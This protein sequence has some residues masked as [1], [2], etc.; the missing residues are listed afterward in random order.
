MS[1]PVRALS[2]SVDDARV[3]A[4]A[5]SGPPPSG[6]PG[7]APLPSQRGAAPADGGSFT[8][9]PSKLW[10]L[11]LIF[12][13]ALT[14]VFYALP[15]YHL[16][17]WTPLGLSSVVATV[18]GVHRYQP[19]QRGGW[20]LLAAGQFCLIAGD[21]TYNV[22]TQFFH[23][24]DPYPSLADVFY[25]A[26]YPLSAVGIYRFV[27]SRSPGRD[28]AGLIDALII[29]TG[30]GLLSWLY[31]VTPNIDVGGSVLDR[32]VSVAYPLG[33]V[34]VLSMLLRLIGSGGVRIRAMQLLIVGA[35]GL[36][37]A[38]VLYGVI[39]LHGVWNV[40]G[41]VDSGWV[42]FYL[43]W[44]AAALHPSMTQITRPVPRRLR[45]MGTLR[46]SLLAGVSLIAPAALMAESI[47]GTGVQAK[48]VAIFSAVLFL[49]VIA[50]LRGIL[51]V[52]Q[53][54]VERER[55][56]RFFG[57]A[58]VAAQGL[59]DIYHAALDGA[60]ALVGSKAMVGAEV[61]VARRDDVSRV[62]TTGEPPERANLDE[63]WLAAADGGRL[64]ASGTLSVTPLRQ[65]AHEPAMLVVDTA[66]ALTLDQQGALSTLAAQVALAV[67]SANLGEDLR[68]RRS[69]ERF[70]GLL[71]NTSD[72]IVIVDSLGRISYSTPSLARNLGRTPQDLLG[73]ELAEFLH[74][75]DAVIAR[76]M[77][78]G[79]AA[80]TT[81]APPMTD[82]RLHH[83]DGRWL[84]FEVLFNNLLDDARVGGVVLTMR[85]VSERRQLE[86][87]LKHQAFHDA[88]TGLPNRALFQD[89]AE[90][91][92]A[93]TARL[94]TLVAMVMVDV[95]DFKLVNDTRGHA[96]GD[97]LLQ[98]VGARLRSTLRGGATI[99]RFGGD[100]FAILVE[101]LTDVSQ[102]E[103]FADRALQCFA[104]PFVIAGEELVARVSIGLVVSGTAPA[105][106]DVDELM[107]CADVALYAAKDRGKGQVVLY[108]GELH[109]RMLDR[110]ARRSDLDRGFRAGEFVL[111]YQPIV[112]IDTG[113]IVGCES[114]VRW[115][116]PVRG[117]VPPMEFVGLAEETGLIVELGRWVLQRSCAQLQQWAQAGHPDLRMS[118]N[119]SARQLE[120]PEFQDD[121]RAV[122]TSHQISP[123]QLV[124]EL[125]ESI[126]ALDAPVMAEQLRVLRDDV[127][128]KI[129]MD[130]FGTGYSSLSY[131][132]KFQ[133]DVLK[134]DKSFVDGLGEDDLDGSALVSAIISLAHSLR[135]EVVAEGIEGAAQRDELWSMGCNLGQGY[136]Y[137][138]PVPAADMAVL[139]SDSAPLGPAGNTGQRDVS[140]LRLP[141]LRAGL[142]TYDG[143]N[144]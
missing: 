41:P 5:S 127:G 55:M 108:H 86:T 13:A 17:L 19:R 121:V 82:W 93:R 38:D 24:T 62:A 56:L 138:R 54:S 1:A 28:R 139:L 137:S 125:T 61:W 69:E 22:L 33:D 40:G 21:T 141:P 90:Q 135:L 63:L 29:T 94:T 6:T 144:A 16:E 15:A 102:A 106:A 92:L 134:V 72:I 101:D 58:L 3:A 83:Y 48:A 114:L 98:N 81:H 43:A 14:A 18:V 117:L 123:S 129:A 89:R 30:L 76:A 85:D 118:V 26:L 27:R 126:F 87:Q 68:A 7:G 116:H 104:N 65:D 99:A 39:Q 74:A 9:V 60:R 71:Q 80:G 103:A 73:L 32:L 88:L 143:T 113:E 11:Y 105:S 112:S 84:A 66:E 131:L 100:E 52:H 8:P 31:L 57:E 67:E 70:Q 124:L 12:G 4:V 45:P 95:D 140:R 36:M 50:R 64:D 25:I 96:V 23:Q 132:Q 136:L 47:S 79:F 122:L 128:V 115:Q 111:H 130:D 119:V 42:I 107:R 37:L 53:Q 133:L 142:A 77:F 120:E 44:G 34:L 97:E 46:V 10:L 109:N 2:T 51:D 110:V 91:A 35:A 20:Y 75:K 78:A 49:L 59:P